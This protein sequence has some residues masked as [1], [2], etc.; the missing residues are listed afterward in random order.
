MSAT[1]LDI[2][3]T[4]LQKSHV[5]LNEIGEAQGI[6]PEKQRAYHALRA[7]LW[8]IRDRLTVEEAFHLSAQLPL[9]IRGMYWDGYRPS[10]TPQ[11]LKSRED[12]FAKVAEELSQVNGPAPEDAANAVF[13]VMNRHVPQGEL[14]HVRGMM[15]KPLEQ[16]MRGAA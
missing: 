1:G 12:F 9:L 15:P 6:G 2:F 4:A 7:V 3:D 5:W 14:E 8:A 13:A 10:Q 16:M 11:K